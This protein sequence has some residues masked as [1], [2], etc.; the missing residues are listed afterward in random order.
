MDTLRKGVTCFDEDLH[1]SCFLN[2]LLVLLIIL[3]SCCGFI[4]TTII[5]WVRRD[6]SSLEIFRVQILVLPRA[7]FLVSNGNNIV[8]RNFARFAAIDVKTD[9]SPLETE[10]AARDNNKIWRS[11]LFNELSSRLTQLIIVVRYKVIFFTR[12]AMKIFLKVEYFVRLNRRATL[13]NV[14]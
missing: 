4:I 11:K 14:A 8:A 2:K 6:E 13:S 7:T 1:K 12:S 10:P 9:K 5:T 3:C